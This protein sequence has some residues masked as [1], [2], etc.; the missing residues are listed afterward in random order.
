[1]FPV[2]NF[3][4]VLIGNTVEILK[5]FFKLF[6]DSSTRLILAH[7]TEHFSVDHGFG[8][9]CDETLTSTWRSM[10]TSRQVS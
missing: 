9:K 2:V 10:L 3:H 8:E 4:T 7:F 5:H 6:V 1:M